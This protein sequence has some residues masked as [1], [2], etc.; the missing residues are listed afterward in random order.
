MN[1]P[2]EAARRPCLAT[3]FRVEIDEGNG[4]IVELGF[5][6]V[7]FPRFGLPAGDGVAPPGDPLVLRRASVATLDLY[8]WWH[9]ARQGK[10]PQRRTLRVMLLSEDHERTLLT[11]RFRNVRPVALSY[12]PLLANEAA[13]LIESLELAFDGM[14][15]R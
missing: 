3:N 11:W 6:E 12:S 7:V 2:H 14:D 15:M 9:R 4:R 8:A 1:R 5:A 10:A 13:L